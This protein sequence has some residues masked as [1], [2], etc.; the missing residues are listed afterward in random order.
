MKRV[1]KT[2]LILGTASMIGSAGYLVYQNVQPQTELKAE[3]KRLVNLNT[4][5][6]TNPNYA[7][8]IAE[9]K[10]LAQERK[11]EKA[12]DKYVKAFEIDNK[13]NLPLIGIAEVYLQSDNLKYA[14][15]NLIKAQIKGPLNT[16]GRT[17]ATRI[18][19]NNQNLELAKQIYDT[20]TETTDESQTIG[21][22]LN[23][24]IQNDTAAEQKLN[25]I[26]SQPANAGNTNDTTTYSK[27][28]TK[29]KEQLEVYKTFTDSPRSYLYAVLA[30]EL[31]NQNEY[32][33]AR[34]LLFASIQEK[35]DY[36]DAW[37][38]LGYSYLL[39]NKNADAIKA[40]EKA[41]QIDPYNGDTYFYLGLAQQKSEQT[42]QSIESLQKAS[43]F[44][45]NNSKETYIQIANSFY[46]DKNYQEANNYYAK[47]AELGQLKIEDYTKIVWLNLEQSS[48]PDKALTYALQALNYYPQ[49]AMAHNLVGWTQIKLNNSTE[50]E[51]Y[52]NQAIVLDPK[53][54]AAF[55]NLGLLNIAQKNIDQAKAY[56]NQ[57]IT[58]AKNN[59]SSSIETRATAELNKLNQP[60]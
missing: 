13:S 35:N 18:A 1:I 46:L 45:F 20:I 44:G 30:K 10:E 41:K 37:L 3:S 7:V 11:F 5:Q 12:I 24:L 47:A 6:S 53:L 48:S 40:L 31:L 60:Q 51:K 49:T 25:A 28:A 14:E 15:E 50:A 19:L 57:A 59:R 58:L 17:I 9:A 52:L 22:V 55:L 21:A 56:L 4:Y 23:F 29:L 43:S 2:I 33:L 38:M 26:I 16:S 27:L 54:D 39:S 8:L 32:I 42:K 36:R 34:P